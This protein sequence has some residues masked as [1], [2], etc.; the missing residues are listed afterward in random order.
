MFST[1]CFMNE[2]CQSQTLLILHY[3]THITDFNSWDK[4]CDCLN[5]FTSLKITV[6]GTSAESANTIFGQAH[7]RIRRCLYWLEVRACFI[8]L[9]SISLEWQ[10]H[11]RFHASHIGHSDVISVTC[12][13]CTQYYLLTFQACQ[14]G[15]WGKDQGWWSSFESRATRRIAWI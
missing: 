15:I 2:A 1:E 6:S 14:H 10:V 7:L 4:R 13:I 3:L 5:K 12:I 11:V 9:P 8:I